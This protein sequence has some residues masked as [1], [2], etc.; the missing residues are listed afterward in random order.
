MESVNI[1]NRMHQR[2]GDVSVRPRHFEAAAVLA[3]DLK[4][5]KRILSKKNANVFKFFILSLAILK[6]NVFAQK[7]TQNSVQ[8]GFFSEIHYL[9]SQQQWLERYPENFRYRLRKE[10]VVEPEKQNRGLKL[11]ENFEIE[12]KMKF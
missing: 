10:I 4:S 7:F 3:R 9:D 12:R 5:S 2:P 8:I 11:V 1:R 6:I